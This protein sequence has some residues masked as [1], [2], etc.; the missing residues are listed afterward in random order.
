[1]LRKTHGMGLTTLERGPATMSSKQRT[2]PGYF[3]CSVLAEAYKEFAAKGQIRMH[4]EFQTLL[5]LYRAIDRSATAKRK[6]DCLILMIQI[7]TEVPRWKVPG[8]PSVIR[9]TTM[10][11]VIG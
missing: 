11:T 2:H 5:D 10:I 7:L 3:L 9:D 4:E 1:M 8:A 6:H